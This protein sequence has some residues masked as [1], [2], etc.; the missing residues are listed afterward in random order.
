MILST[1]KIYLKSELLSSQNLYLGVPGLICTSTWIIGNEIAIF[2]PNF[3]TR[4]RSVLT[5]LGYVLV[6]KKMIRIRVINLDL[7]P[8]H[9]LG[10][11]IG[12]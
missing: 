6:S 3:K 1:E 9:W 10:L 12:S 8:K 5:Y 4:S 2:S 11:W 7:I